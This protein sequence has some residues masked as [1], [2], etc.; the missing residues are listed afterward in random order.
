MPRKVLHQRDYTGYTIV[1]AI[2]SSLLELDVIHREF[3]VLDKLQLMGKVTAKDKDGDIPLQSAVISKADVPTAKLILNYRHGHDKRAMLENRNNANE[4]ALEQSLLSENTDLFKFLLRECIKSK[5]LQNL[6]C[7]G[8]ANR[9]CD[10]LV[11]KC[12]IERRI[13]CF[14][15][16]LEVCKECGEQPD[17]CV[18]DEKGYT[19]W[20]YL[21]RY[22]VDE[23]PLVKQVLSVLEK[24]KIPISSLLVNKT[25]KE[26]MLHKAYRTGNEELK[27]LLGKY[28]LCR[29]KLDGF[30]RVPAQ[31][32]RILRNTN[33]SYMT[34]RS[35]PP[36]LLQTGPQAAATRPAQPPQTPQAA[37]TRPA[38]LPQTGPQ[39][40]AT[41]TAQPPQTGPQAAATRPAQLPQTGP[42]AAATC[43]A[44]PPQ[45]GPQAATTR[46]AQPPQTPQAA[47]TC[48]AQP[49]QTGL[50]AGAKRS[51]QPPQTG[52]QAGA[53]R[54]AQAP[55]IG[56]QFIVK[57]PTQ[58][59]QTGRPAQA[60]QTGPLPAAKHPAQPPQTGLQVV[61]KLPTQSPQTGQLAGMKHLS[62][63][64]IHQSHIK[65]ITCPATVNMFS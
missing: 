30:K 9:Q 18:G 46:P 36:Q 49:P 47:A 23:M 32:N 33:R 6:T 52:L 44:Q 39:A 28:E 55:Q 56:P 22:S 3:Q 4:T 35:N 51:A 19:P 15:A 48:P 42:Q 5:I 57:L 37:A 43:P 21:L 13:T 63:T 61:V 34:P 8:T 20:Q 53:K 2:C 24:Y 54:T 62:K 1:H 60:P 64:S 26:T 12:I 59:P 50:Q 58:S 27:D 31:R 45:T 38:Q 29:V 65:V 14:C 16:F 41:R 40:A 11:H 25:S 7:I 17:L 10:T